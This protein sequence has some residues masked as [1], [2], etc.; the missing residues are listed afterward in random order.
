V[1]FRRGWSIDR[2]RKTVMG[3]AALLM[4]AGIL[5]VRVENPMMALTLIGVVLF[6]FQAWVANLQTM[7]S[8]IFPDRSVGAVAGLGGTGSGLSTMLCTLA[9]GWTVDHFSY[10]P[11]LTAAGL[12]G[13]IG[14][15]TVFT[16]C[17]KIERVQL[18]VEEKALSKL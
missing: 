9:I 3:I 13:P 10:T 5:A 7:P 4:P 2:A 8:D 12:L 16:L 1:L 6:G 17:G 14:A 11:V 15:I 18:P